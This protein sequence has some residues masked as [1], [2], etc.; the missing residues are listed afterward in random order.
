MMLG[1]VGSGVVE[2]ASSDVA[3][4]VGGVGVPPPVVWYA[5]VAEYWW[6]YVIGVGNWL[7]L[8]IVNVAVEVNQRSV[9]LPTIGLV[10]DA[11]EPLRAHIV[12]AGNCDSCGVAAVC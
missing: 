8:V 4:S 9:E 11:A 1:L 7:G 12:W 3:V 6:K 10:G 5:N 2:V